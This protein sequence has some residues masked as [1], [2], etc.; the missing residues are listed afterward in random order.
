M[1]ESP[2]MSDE[3]DR[4]ITGNWG[5]DSVTEDDFDDECDGTDR[6]ADA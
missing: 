6:P 1:F 2:R 5:E 4:W 3:L